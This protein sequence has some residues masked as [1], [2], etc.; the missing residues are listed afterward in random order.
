MGTK[1]VTYYVCD[2]CGAEAER[3]HDGYGGDVARE[4]WRKLVFHHMDKTMV[5]GTRTMD[6][7]MLCPPCAEAA[8]VFVGLR[9]G[10]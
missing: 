2:K 4:P 6:A 5:G 1:T 9:K 8:Y 7:I 10:K 3:T